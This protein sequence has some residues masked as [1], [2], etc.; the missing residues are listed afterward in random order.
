MFRIINAFFPY[1][2]ICARDLVF[3]GFLTA[4]LRFLRSDN[5]PVKIMYNKLFP[6]A[7]NVNNPPRCNNTRMKITQHSRRYMIYY[8]LVLFFFYV[9]RLIICLLARFFFLNILRPAFNYIIKPY[10][11][12]LLSKV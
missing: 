7:L 5:R 4:R 3:H 9:S 12:R 10:A 2:R 1:C 11:E 6:L 8:M